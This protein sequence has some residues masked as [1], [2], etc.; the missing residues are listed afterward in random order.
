MKNRSSGRKNIR[1]HACLI[2]L[3]RI[4][5]TQLRGFR[6]SKVPNILMTV[7]SALLAMESSRRCLQEFPQ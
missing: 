7:I 4:E 6:I 3:F 5:F 1:V 2:R